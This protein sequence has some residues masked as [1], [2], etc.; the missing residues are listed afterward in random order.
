MDSPDRALT[1]SGGRYISVESYCD[2]GEP[3]RTPVDFVESGGLLY[4]RTDPRTQKVKRIQGNHHVRV[5]PCDMTGRPTG[6]WLD[7]D[8]EVVEG[9]ARSKAL[10]VFRKE[11][12]F[13]GNAMVG[14]VGRLRG[15][16]MTMVVSVRLR[17]SP[18]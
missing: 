18:S 6:P 17:P 5:A 11:Y 16:R 15:N 9:E 1:F 13:L 8:A 7:A 14:L 10:R 12:G 4:F 3:R 2:G